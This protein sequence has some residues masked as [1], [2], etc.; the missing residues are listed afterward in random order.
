[1]LRQMR[2]S[3]LFLSVSELK[4]RKKEI[5]QR[6]GGEN[7]K[8]Q[9]ERGGGRIVDSFGKGSSGTLLRA[10]RKRLLKIGYHRL[11]FQTRRKRG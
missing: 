5:L 9:E 11:I 7:R 8:L 3:A 4:S 2:L 6:R 1:L 10:V